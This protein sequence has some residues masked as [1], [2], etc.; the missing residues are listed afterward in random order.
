MKVGGRNKNHDILIV[1]Q[2]V[3]K[4]LIMW[5]EEVRGQ[6]STGV[7]SRSFLYL[8][9]ILVTLSKVSTEQS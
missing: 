9:P 8:P 4:V 1:A 6:P 3:W 7:Q 2:E 5:G